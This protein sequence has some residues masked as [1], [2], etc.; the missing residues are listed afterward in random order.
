MAK[1]LRKISSNEN[2]EK[3][4][5]ITLFVA[6]YTIF[7]TVLLVLFILLSEPTVNTIK[8]YF[9]K[10]DV[11][12]SSVL[13]QVLL[14]VL[15]AVLAVFISSATISILKKYSRYKEVEENLKKI[16]R[17]RYSSLGD[18][19]LYLERQISE[20]NTKLVS[21]ETRW[22]EVYHLLLTAQER[23]LKGSVSGVISTSKFLER[24]GIDTS[25]IQ[26]QNNLVFVLTP[27]HEDYDHTYDV[28][29][30]TCKKI[31]LN[32]M[33]GD[34]DNIPKDVLQNIIKCIVKSRIVVA[35]LNGR[36]PN[37]FYE[38]GIAQALNKPTIL[39]SYRDEPIPFDFKNQYLIFYKYDDD[40]SAQ[41]SDACLK[42]LAS[43]DYTTS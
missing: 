6:C 12:F 32:A 21:S 9:D 1:N 35:N 26:I 10:M 41:L 28:I 37:V 7:L 19:R 40:L 30:D 14:G 4:N 8:H 36:N 22:M 3:K 13:L 29:N 18:E 23:Q 31:K 16:E 39:L 33:R 43:N 11:D 27:F 15:S 17:T 20:L 25:A 5:K 34:E 2:S 24:F 38:L 42:I